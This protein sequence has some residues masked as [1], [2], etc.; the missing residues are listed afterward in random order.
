MAERLLGPTQQLPRQFLYAE[1]ILSATDLC[2]ENSL[3]WIA[4]FCMA[5]PVAQ[6]VIYHP[7][8]GVW[9]LFPHHRLDADILPR[10]IEP[11]A[12]V[13][14]DQHAESLALTSPFS[15]NCGVV[16]HS[17]DSIHSEPAFPETELI[18]RETVLPDQESLMPL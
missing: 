15:C 16:N 17:L 8:L 5:L 3:L 12:H 2:A 1:T 6:R 18:F 10:G 14:A 4:W 9:N 13:N 7:Q 11:I